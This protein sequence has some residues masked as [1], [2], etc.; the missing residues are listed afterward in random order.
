MENMGE[1]RFLHEER[2]LI[3]YAAMG[4]LTLIFQIYVRSS[5]CSSLT[6]CMSSYFKA[7]VWAIF[8]PFSWIVYLAGF[9]PS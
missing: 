4:V 3:A 2:H 5:Q 6:D 9:L 8:W 1:P 7:V